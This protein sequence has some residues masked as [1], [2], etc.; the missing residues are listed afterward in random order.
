MS[1]RYQ[2]ALTERSRTV[3][4]TWVRAGNSGM[5]TSLLLVPDVVNTTGKG[6]G[7]T[8]QRQP[9]LLSV[10]TEAMAK[11]CRNLVGELFM[12]DIGGMDPVGADQV[13]CP[14]EPLLGDRIDELH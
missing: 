7:F 12:A 9:A 10:D 8:D 5:T 13:R 14:D 4:A 3:I 6:E 1:A 2:G 11:E